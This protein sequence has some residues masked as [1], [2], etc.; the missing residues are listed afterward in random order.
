M[1]SAPIFADQTSRSLL[2]L[3]IAMAATAPCGV[4]ASEATPPPRCAAGPLQVPSP[5]W[6]DQ[7][8][9]LAMIDRFDDGDSSN[10]DQGADE[11]DP[12]DGRRYSGGDLAGLLRRVDYLRALGITAPQLGPGRVRSTPRASQAVPPPFW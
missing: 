4:R 1:R 9:Y 7:I 6:R 2:V 8:M 10:N 12:A 3:L 5:D 11:Y